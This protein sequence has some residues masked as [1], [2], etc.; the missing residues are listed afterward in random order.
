MCFFFFYYPA[1]IAE[2]CPISGKR[3]EEK[4]QL[5]NGKVSI[6]PNVEQIYSIMQAKTGGLGVNAEGGPIYGEL[7]K[8]AFQKI[9]NCMKE[10]MEFNKNSCFIDL[11]SGGGK[12]NLHV[13]QDPGVAISI[14]VETVRNRWIQGLNNAV[15]VLNAAAHQQSSKM[16]F[17]PKTY[18]CFRCFFLN[19][20]I[21]DAA[22][23]D[24]ATHV[25]MY[26]VGFPEVLFRKLSTMFNLSSS[27]Y[28]IC[29]EPPEV[30]CDYYGFQVKPFVSKY[31][32]EILTVKTSM[33]GSNR[34]HTCYFYRRKSTRK[35]TQVNTC[36]PMF[37][38]AVQHI[39]KGFNHLFAFTQHLQSSLWDNTV[40]TSRSL[41]PREDMCNFR[42]FELNWNECLFKLNAHRTEDLE[43]QPSSRGGLPNHYGRIHFRALQVRIR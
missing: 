1:D 39:N 24:P 7:T 4:D 32:S 26:S 25:Y 20:D 33:H 6:Q 2:A 35:K 28:L 18:I 23:F 9:V 38:T 5:N 22:T 11:G 10:F 30:I 8:G 21:T 42:H 34:V 27:L 29:Y 19:M 16:R 3:A 13:S 36:D 15:G 14:G 31:D 37:R 41:K 43:S 40:D 12:P 17:D